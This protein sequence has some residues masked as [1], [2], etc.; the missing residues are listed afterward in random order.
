M[1]MNHERS[2]ERLDQFCTSLPLPKLLPSADKLQT[3]ALVC[4]YLVEGSDF[5]GWIKFDLLRVEQIYGT[6]PYI[7]CIGMGLG[8]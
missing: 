7:R 6:Q 4:G 3:K 8:S 5:E 2:S 1:T